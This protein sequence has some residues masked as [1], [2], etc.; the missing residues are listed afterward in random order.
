MKSLEESQARADSSLSSYFYNWENRLL[1]LQEQVL[2]DSELASV[3][4]PAQIDLM[5]SNIQNIR[6]QRYDL[7]KGVD[8]VSSASSSS[9]NLNNSINYINGLYSTLTKMGENTIYGDTI[10]QKFSD[11]YNDLYIQT[12]K[13]LSY[14]KNKIEQNPSLNNDKDIQLLL[15]QI[16]SAGDVEEQYINDLSKSRSESDIIAEANKSTND[17]VIKLR[18]EYEDNKKAVS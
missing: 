10:V 1:S 9:D 15:G 4:D 18:K 17:E 16:S 11:T 12:N 13:I 2:E 3:Y 14:I 6:D 8:G 5:I 7:V